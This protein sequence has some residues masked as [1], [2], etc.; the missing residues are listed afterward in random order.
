[1]IESFARL[2]AHIGALSSSGAPRLVAIDGPSGG[3][4]STFAARLAHALGAATVIELD[5]FV[6]W[7]DL[8]GW[9]P[10]LEEQVLGPLLQ[11]RTATYQQRDWR[12]D[13]EGTGLGAWRSVPASSVVLL[14]GVT[15]SRRELAGRLSYAVWIDAPQELRLRRGVE[16]DGEQ[17]RA[18]WVD[19]MQR[20][21]AFF[22]SDGARQRANL[23]V[24]GAPTTPHAPEQEFIVVRR[25]A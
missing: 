13:P 17:M 22:A 8:T 6:S 21:D 12:G 14:E 16:R 24:E 20:E 23:T 4:K 25:L 15:S 7:G 3:G 10:R 18:H 2:A 1:L 9:W 5:D 19:W 11:G